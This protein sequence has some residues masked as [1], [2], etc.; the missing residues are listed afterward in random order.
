MTTRDLTNFQRF[1]VA[2]ESTAGL[3]TTTEVPAM[4]RVE[5][6]RVGT[7]CLSFDQ[8]LAKTGWTKLE[9]TGQG[10]E[11]KARGIIQAPSSLNLR[12]VTDALLAQQSIYMQ[13]EEI[14]KRFFTVGMVIAHETPP[15]PAAVR[16]SG[17]SSILAA[18]ALHNAASRHGLTPEWIAR[19]TWA[20]FVG[21]SAKMEKKDVHEKLP[22]WNVLGDL[23]TN[24]AQ[25][26][27]L[28]IGLTSLSRRA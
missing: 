1:A 25:R 3:V 17:M 19:P 13:A 16:G 5:M 8:S 23:P 20:K 14:I 10:I 2:P 22:G 26:D 27:A 18:A 6:F 7:A 28:C 15:N 11:C 12:S 9:I 24:E 21:G 4:A